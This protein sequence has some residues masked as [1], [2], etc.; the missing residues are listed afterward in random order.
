MNCETEW[1]PKE[2]HLPVIASRPA[3]PILKN[4]Q[5]AVLHAELVKSIR[6]MLTTTDCTPSPP[7]AAHMVSLSN[8]PPELLSSMSFNQL[9]I[10]DTA[11]REPERIP[12]LRSYKSVGESHTKS[13]K[14]P[15]RKL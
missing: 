15:F 1:D 13:P 3:P 2:L 9:P 8:T 10:D 11:L 12:P 14:T 4:A 5:N 6:E 7:K